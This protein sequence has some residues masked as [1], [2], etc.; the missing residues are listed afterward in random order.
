MIVNNQKKIEFINDCN[1]M[2]NYNE[3]E[4]A[5]IWYQDRPT[6]RLRH[7]YLFGNYP[8]ITIHK[9]KIHIHRLLM[10][11]WNNIKKINRNIYVHHIDGNKLNALKD[12]LEFIEASKHQSQH[13]KGRIISDY[14]REIIRLNNMKRKG[15][16]RGIIRKDITYFKIYELYKKGYSINK[17]SKELNYEW[18][19]VKLRLK[20][21]FD[22]KNLLEEE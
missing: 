7:I 6:T 20:E 11:Y 16:K 18:S 12:N 8:A 2:V 21:I 10:M 22:N 5:I 1:C 9:E 15:I 13:N 19:Q 14:Q 17:I 4:K 3:L